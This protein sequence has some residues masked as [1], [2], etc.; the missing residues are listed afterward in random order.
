MIKHIYSSIQDFTIEIIGKA[1]RFGKS[2]EIDDINGY[3]GSL[4]T[5]EDAPI[6]T[7]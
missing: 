2:V 7:M 4:E 5:P 3:T 6:S 1:T